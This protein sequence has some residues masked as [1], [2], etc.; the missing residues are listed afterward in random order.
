MAKAPDPLDGPGMDDG[1]SFFESLLI[2]FLIA[3]L[4]VGLGSALGLIDRPDPQP[5]CQ[6]EIIVEPYQ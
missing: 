5:D 3:F 4:I 6:S 1:P 2:I